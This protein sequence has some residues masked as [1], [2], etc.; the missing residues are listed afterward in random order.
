MSRHDL[1]LPPSITVKSFRGSGAVTMGS[2]GCVAITKS[3]NQG[4]A[5]TCR[6]R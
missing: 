6:T 5:D 3:S 4:H 2:I 1:P